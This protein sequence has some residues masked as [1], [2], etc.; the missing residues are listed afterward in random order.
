MNRWGLIIFILGFFFNVAETAY[1]G[2]N[3]E[4]MSQAEEIA[5]LYCS[6]L[7]GLGILMLLIGHLRRLLQK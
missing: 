2:W 5:D 7:L 1:F 6:K 3:W 4:A